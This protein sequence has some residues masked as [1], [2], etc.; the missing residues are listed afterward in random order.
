MKALAS[1]AVNV[2]FASAVAA[3][4]P[5]APFA[6]IDGGTVSL[7]DFAGKPV[8]LVNTASMCGYTPQYE[9]LQ[10]LYDTYRDQGLVV[11]AVPSD[12]FQ[13]ELSSAAEV[14]EFCAI[15]YNITLPMTDITHV[16]GPQAHPVYAWLRDE[17]GFVPGWN[18]NK[19][20]IGRDGAIL[21]T[22]PSGP[23]PMSSQIVGAVEAALK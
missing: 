16:K 14:K 1:F 7:A 11:L 18:F 2:L 15:N 19:V 3:M 6:S 22:W 5:A 8:L 10:A 4:P 12:D 21:G 23:K 9:G 13:Q 17:A 20:L